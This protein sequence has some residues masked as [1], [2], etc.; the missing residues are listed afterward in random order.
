MPVPQPQALCSVTVS[1]IVAIE[2][3]SDCP[4]SAPAWH[5]QQ[6]GGHGCTKCQPVQ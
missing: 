5:C 1:N 4:I 2:L 3:P 6:P